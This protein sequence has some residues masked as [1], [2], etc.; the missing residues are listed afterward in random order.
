MK[1]RWLWL[2]AVVLSALL[3]FGQTETG[4]ITGTVTDPSGAVVPN[5]QV[6]VVGA[7]TGVTRTT[8]T[9]DTGLYTVS[10]LQPGIYDVTVAAPGFA[11]TKQRVT[12]TVGGRAAAELK[13]Q[14]AT[15]STT[16]EVTAA[17]AVEVNTE[18]PTLSQ[19]VTSQSITQ[20]PTI[21][22][23]PY[24]LVATS[25]FV[26]SDPSGS[27]TGRGVDA[28]INGQRAASTNILLDGGENV[29]TFDTTVGTNVPLDSVQEFRVMTN[30]FT[31]EYGRA[32]GGVVNVATKS[33]T[34]SFHGTAYEF[35]RG[36][37]LSANTAEN[38]AND[39]PKDNFVRNQ[40]GYSLG[41]PVLKNK[42]FF[43]SSTEWIRVRSK[44]LSQY[45][46][47]T[48]EFIG[49]AAPA[50][51]DFMNAYGKLAAQPDTVF[52]KDQLINDLGGVTDLA[53]TAWGAVPATFPVLEQVTLP[54]ATDVGGGIPQNTVETVGRVDLNLSQKTQ[55]YGRYALQNGEYFPGW[56]S[57]SP[58]AGFLTGE[59]I[60]NQNI[61]L[62]LTRVFGNNFVSQSKVIYNRLFDLQPLNGPPTPTLFYQNRR[63]TIGGKRAY[64]PG[65]LPGNPGSGIPFGGP[66]NL[67]QFYEDLGWTHANHNFRF[68]GNY[69][70][71]RDNRVFGAY[72]EAAQ[73]LG[74]NVSTG[75]N[76]FLLGQLTGYQAA[77]NP[78]GKFPCTFNYATGLYND[79]D[80]S[81][82]IN[83]PATSPQFNRN[84]RFN[85]FALY[86]QDTWKVVPRLT[87]TLG[88]RYEYYGVQHNADPKLDSNFYFGPGNNYFEQYRNGSVQVAPDSPV[89][90]LWEPDKNNFA[91]RFGFAWDIFGNGKSSLRGG[92]GIAYERNFGNVT[93]NVIQNPPNY[94]V[95][96]LSPSDVGGN[97]PVS[98][99]NLGS[100]ETATG[101]KPLL[102]PSLRHISQN[103]RT[104]YS[105][106]WNL[107]WEE[108][109][110]HNSL[111]AVEYAGSRGLKLYSLEDPNRDGAS[112]IYLG[113]PLPATACPDDPACGYRL[114]QTY[115]PRSY[116]RSNRGF[117]YYNALNL[118]LQ[119]NNIRNTGLSFT[120]N[121]TWSHAIDNLS[122]TFS[123]SYANYNTGLLDPFNPGLDKGSADFDIRHRFVISGLW[124]EPWLKGR[125][126]LGQVLGGW[127][128]APIITLRTGSPYTLFDCS[129]S[130]PSFYC[131][132]AQLIGTPALV[133]GGNRGAV[134]A[135]NLFDYQG[136]P[137]DVGA[138]VNPLTGTAEFGNCTTPGQGATGP[139][140]WPS[141][142][143]ARNYFVGPNNWS[144][145]LGL[146]KNF[147]I[148]ERVRL[149][150]RGEFYNLFN[151]P[152]NYIEANSLDVSGCTNFADP[153]ASSGPCNY[154][155]P[156]K[157][158][159]RPENGG[160]VVGEKRD[161]QLALKIIF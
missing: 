85:D 105:E 160:S 15:A 153:T 48:P 5:A 31:A 134:Q 53:G 109:L 36:A 111:F 29:N 73:T 140:P 39:L 84:N 6:T 117:S 100:F 8:Q 51:Q 17:G 151:H 141:N 63:A 94:A 14:P 113:S 92:Y 123:D 20:L 69:I 50:T 40:F 54:I 28:A 9:T 43:F 101:V 49:L 74:T 129:V 147:P 26:T 115:G 32:S 152:N 136:A 107:S 62:N 71:M 116:N 96:S 144:F 87:L 22:R 91:P 24:D 37:A 130:G 55:L 60:R 89:G 23:N 146:Y 93:F 90:G 145:N 2:I 154:V 59:K 27:T 4:V 121:Y 57:E 11:Q 13:L 18:S 78:Q 46:V 45:L 119:T 77:I 112:I 120:A 97:L 21:T 83:L 38:K 132:R 158:G 139:C 3:A 108:Q 149:Q 80:P 64:L 122:S 155:V 76:N 72:E 106:M 82:L 10:N 114:N 142:M 118:R 128:L 65:Y 127:E 126:M 16:V 104:A 131:P 86:A 56:I 157:A 34:N 12:V 25:G 103:I 47:P 102:S 124:S 81:C 133:A 79:T 7:N 70:H 1:L 159:W 44:Q 138:Y 75:L 150:L 156:V 135:P 35:Y 41:G 61:L 110:G 58:Y 95:I 161:I 88:L 143:V 30:D 33:G 125:G 67:Y 66:Q 148:S 42:L 68:G 52:T 98:T 137:V 19:V 99:A